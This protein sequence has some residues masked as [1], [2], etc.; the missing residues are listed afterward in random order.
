MFFFRGDSF[1]YFASTDA[2]YVQ[3]QEK[4]TQFEIDGE[5]GYVMVVLTEGSADSRARPFWMH[6]FLCDL[7]DFLFVEC[8]IQAMFLFQVYQDQVGD[9]QAFFSH[10][11][12]CTTSRTTA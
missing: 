6:K 7:H 12:E 11:R 8:A 2:A 3:H 5:H 4:S 1:D 9:A 10:V